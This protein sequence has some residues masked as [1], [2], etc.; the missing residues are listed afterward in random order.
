MSLEQQAYRQWTPGIP[1]GWT[2]SN[3]I[4]QGEIIGDPG[5][6]WRVCELYR[7]GKGERLEYVAP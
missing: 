6:F 1:D 4:E 5:G 3:D 7:R 2:S